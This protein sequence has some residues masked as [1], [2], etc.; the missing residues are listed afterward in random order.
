[1]KKIYRYLFLGLTVL[2]FGSC[3]DLDTAPQGR[4]VTSTQKSDVAQADPS[5]A[6]ASVNAIFSR[7]NTGMA[8]S[9][10]HN[11]FGLPAIFIMAD[12]DGYDYVS[13]RIVY[14]WFWHELSYH[15][16][17]FTDGDNNFQ[18]NTLYAIIYNSNNIAAL[19]DDPTT[20]EASDLQFY[21]GQAYAMRA[22]AYWWLAQ[23]YQ[24]TYKGHEDD[25]CVPI[26]T[27][28][29]MGSVGVEGCPRATVQKV[30]EQM[31]SD[32]D[33]AIDLLGKTEKVRDDQRYINKQVALGIRARI[34]LYAEYWEQAAADAKAAQEGFTPY[35]IAD[36]SQPG[37][38]TLV[39]NTSFMW[40]DVLAE[41]DPVVTSGI[42]NWSS[43]TCSFA[44][45]YTIY[46]GWRS[47]NKKLFDQIPT[48]DVRKGWWTDADGNSPN[49]SATQKSFLVSREAPAYVNVKFGPYQD[50]I[51]NS[52]NAQPI[53]MMRVEEMV[54]MEAEA[55][56]MA[57][58]PSQGAQILEN[59]VKTYRNPS[60]TCTATTAQAVQEEVYFQRRIELWGEG[61]S[62]FDIKRLKKAMDRRGGGYVSTTVIF[63]IAA[64]DPVLLYQIPESEITNNVQISADQ[65]NPDITLP[66]AVPDED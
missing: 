46:G 29:N 4:Y 21:L 63:N 41:T 26:V 8:Y 20:V 61:L 57:G 14:N 43:H 7:E 36:V 59:F 65:N 22:Y 18:W 30:Y 40:A 33:I 58:N 56:A 66:T 47:I 37:M 11:D 53:P 60:Y 28:E 42:V 52:L 48:T 34:E 64:N 32:I 45:G 9:E 55:T 31:K 49:I 44:Y 19:V 12:T 5:K 24:F 51:T 13:E 39:G 38:N 23:R 1:M 50:Q 15:S 17:R 10:D 27:Q 35:S 6:E 62:W 16:H 2:A 54:L 3:T 25:P